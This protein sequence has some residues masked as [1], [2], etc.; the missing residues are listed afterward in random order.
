MWALH[1]S[2]ANNMCKT[3]A[4][5]APAWL[6]PQRQ[7]RWR[8]QVLPLR[9]RLFCGPADRQGCCPKHH[10]FHAAVPTGAPPTPL[11]YVPTAAGPCSMQQGAHASGRHAKCRSIMTDRAWLHI[12]MP[13]HGQQMPLRYT[14]LIRCAAAFQLPTRS[15]AARA[16]MSAS[17]TNTKIRPMAKVPD[18]ITSQAASAR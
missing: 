7:R 2:R 10:P 15:T 3:R 12:S 18:C 9:R 5:A 11:P 14:D 13:K 6:D 4:P 8:L 16:A 17:S 1:R